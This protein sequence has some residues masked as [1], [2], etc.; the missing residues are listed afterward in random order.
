AAIEWADNTRA[1]ATPEDPGVQRLELS[2]I[3]DNHRAIA[4]YESLGFKHEGA[5]DRKVRHPDGS[6]VADLNMALWLDDQCR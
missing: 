1:T 6:Y 5:C 4:L 3:G 2:V